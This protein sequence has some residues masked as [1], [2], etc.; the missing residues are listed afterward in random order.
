MLSPT[1]LVLFECSEPSEA[2]L[3]VSTFTI[4]RIEEDLLVFAQECN[5]VTGL[6][7]GLALEQALQLLK[8]AFV[9]ACVKRPQLIWDSQYI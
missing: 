2:E 8:L 1:I 5:V 7:S 9:L 6:N 3:R 4:V